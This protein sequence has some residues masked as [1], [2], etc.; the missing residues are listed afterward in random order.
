[1]SNWYMHGLLMFTNPIQ[2]CTNITGLDGIREWIYCQNG[3]NVSVVLLG[4]VIGMRDL[5][6]LTIKIVIWKANLNS[7]PR[8]YNSIRYRF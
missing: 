8:L 3:R 4:Y 6:N 1:M 2:H 5:D 7:M